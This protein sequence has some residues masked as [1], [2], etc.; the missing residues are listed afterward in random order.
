M[1]KGVMFDF[2]GTLLRCESVEEWLGAVLAEAEVPVDGEEFADWVRRLTECGGLPGGPSPQRIPPR[3]EG[4]WHERDLSPDQHRAVY[5]ALIEEAGLPR[6]EL[7]RAL[8]DRHKAPAAWRPYPD[9]GTT[10]RALRRRG[11]P[12]AVVSNIG[13]DLRP[14]FRAH[15]L[16]GLVDAYVLSY[17]QG[18]HKP[19]PA[20]FRAAC[21]ALGLSPSDVLMVGDN[22]VADGGAEA[23]G[24]PV[25]F[26]DHLPVDQRP[27]GLAPVLDLLG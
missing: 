1:V 2:S 13:W 7:T 6:P 26:V 9:T 16:D 4:P 8:Y 24:C 23:L 20:I 27:A 25:H 10:L 22:R 12:V 18:T 19:D 3:L 11:I 21:D 14:V 15:D 5:S 17:E